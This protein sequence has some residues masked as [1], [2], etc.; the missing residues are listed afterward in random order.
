MKNSN[1]LKAA[2]LLLAGLL[3]MTG[4]APR[5]R[6]TYQAPASQADTE[7]VV[8][9]AP[10]LPEV[11]TMTIAPGPGFVWVPGAWSWRSEWVW[12][13]G[14]WAHPPQPGAVWV[15]PRY[16]ARDGKHVFIRGGWKY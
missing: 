1:V 8:E 11:E 15:S 7:V 3:L 10:P 12:D 14:H 4:C 9:Q 5:E 2:R 16:E 6:T 13:Q